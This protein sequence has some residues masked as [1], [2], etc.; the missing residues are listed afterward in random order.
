MSIPRPATSSRADIAVLSGFAAVIL[1]V[2]FY[3]GNGYGFHRDELQF[4]DDARHLQWGFV[5]YPPMTAFC[6]RIAISLFGISPQVFRLPAALVNAISLV[7]A[8]LIARELGGRRA[9]QVV[10]VVATFPLVLVFS[11][12]L[13]YNTLDLLAWSLIVYFVARLLRTGDERNWIGVG[14]GIGIGVLSKYSIAFPVA[15]L[16]AGLVILPSQRKH[17]RTRWFWYGALTATIIAAPNLIWLAS[18]HF[19]T[20]QME[21]FIHARDVRHGRADGYYTDQIKFTMFAFPL[22]VA[23]LVSL[24]CSA[25][26]RFLSVLYIGPFVLFALAKGRGYYLMAAYPLLFAAGAVLLERGLDHCGRLLR[27]S[28]R[29]VVLIALM[30]DT[31][32]VAWAYLP[33][34]R[35]GSAGWNWQMKNNSDMKDEVGWPELVAQVAAVR[36]T[37]S[38]E[39]RSRLAVLANNYGEAGAVALYGPQYGLPTPISSTNTFHMRGYGPYEPET[40]IV[41]GGELDDQLK[42]FES[43]RVAAE[44]NIP[45]G[46]RNEEAVDHP[47]ILVCKHLRWPWAVAWARSQEFG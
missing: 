26:F 18:H 13:Q 24:L 9:A 3:I 22:A 29:S 20:L 25:R 40:V 28:L 2:H 34:W 45:Y 12:V 35:P 1:A 44:V 14:V 46:V 39:E 15:S 32:A 27:V 7:I 10:T 23:G 19:I 33:V 21:Q 31:A 42:N 6:G 47:V 37:L 30:V 38:A 43:C 11:S 8:V 16:L 41:L 17:L 5:A 4:L 36:D